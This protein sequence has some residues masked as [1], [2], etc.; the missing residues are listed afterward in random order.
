VRYWAIA[1]I[2]AA[3]FLYFALRG[4]SWR[5][6]WTTISNADPL[7]VTYTVLIG[8]G[9]LMLRALRW[10]VLLTSRAPVR[11]STAFWA[12]TAG[13]FGNSF[14]PARAGELIRTLY[15]SSQTGLPK[16]FVLT[17]ALTERLSDA[18]TLVLISSIVLLTLPYRPGWFAKAAE[19]FAIIGVTGALAIILLPLLEGLWRRILLRLPLSEKLTGKL[20]TIMEHVLSGIRA[21]HDR[22]RLFRFVGLML[23]IWFLDAISTLTLMRSLGMHASIGVAFLLITSLGLGSALPATPGYVGIFQFVAVS[24]L[25]PF[26]FTRSEAIAYIIFNQAINYVGNAVWGVIAFSRARMPKWRSLIDAAEAEA[27]VSQI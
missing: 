6:V 20:L 27:P 13:Y 17:T 12:T 14:L 10:R 21:F 8:A 11:F 3:V 25:V 9:A 5:D 22:G 23:I 16:M 24:V 19:P 26:G 2:I 4:I 18:V 15:I 1:L 7:W